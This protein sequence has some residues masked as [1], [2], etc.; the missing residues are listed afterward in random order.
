MKNIFLLSALL[1]ISCENSFAQNPDAWIE[2]GN[3]SFY[4]KD[5][6]GALQY[7]KNATA[8]DKTNQFTQAIYN[9]GN[10][11]YQ[12][13]KY[14][15]AIKKYQEFISVSTSNELKAL[16]FFNIGNCYLTKN[17]LPNSITAF[18]NALKLNPQ[19]EDARY[20]LSYAISKLNG[21]NKKE[22]ES[23]TPDSAPSKNEK[24]KSEPEN[25]NMSKEDLDKLLKSLSQ[26]E[27]N[28]LNGVKQDQ[29]KTNKKKSTK[30]W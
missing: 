2:K 27:S 4:Q 16:S 10:T 17:D 30:N 26:A 28:T 1:F 14:D 20:N 13:K 22:D 19:D 23:P 3:Q 5:Y 21:R 7:F 12:L 25:K 9:S 11:F 24:K 18:K 29:Y 15:E 6:N 8:S